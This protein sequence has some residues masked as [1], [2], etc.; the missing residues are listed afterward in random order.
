MLIIVANGVPIL[1][2]DLLHRRFA[3]P[4]DL[5]V[6]LP[7]GERLFGSSKTVRGLLLTVPVTAAVAELVGLSWQMGVTVAL[8]AMA[9]DLFSSFIKRRLHMASGSR[10][11]G[12]D[13]VPESLFPVL[14][15]A[16]T[17]SL[18]SET[19]LATVIAFSVLEL[20]LSRILFRLHLRQQPY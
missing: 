18:H 19:V 5:G 4:L 16:E 10:A 11:L 15:V 7:D 13:Q 9:G 17:L 2:C 3:M 1:A 12:I 14:A 8:W 6:S 20:V